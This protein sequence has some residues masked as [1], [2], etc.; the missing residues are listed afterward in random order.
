MNF[1][2]IGQVGKEIQEYENTQIYI[3]GVEPNTGRYLGK[4]IKGYYFSQK[5][6]LSLIDLYYNS[7]YETGEF[8]AEGQRKLFLNI[9]AFRADV[10]S[11]QIDLDTKDFTF[12]PDGK[13]Y[14]WSAFYIQKKFRQWARESYFGDFIN[15]LV[16]NFPKYG[17]LVVKKV[18]DRLVRVPLRDIIIQQDAK[19]IASA[20]Y[21]I[22]EHRGMTIEDM[23]QY[24]DWDVSNVELQYGETTTVYE[25]Y[26]LVPYGFY[27]KA[28]DKPC[29]KDQEDDM[30][31]CVIVAT[32]KANEKKGGFDGNIL[33]IEKIDERP[34]LEVHWKKQ[35][36]RWL[37]VGEVENQFENQVARNMISNMRTRSLKWASKKV[38]QSAGDAIAKNLIRD[39]KDGDVLEVGPNGAIT[40]VDAAS[41]AT[42]EF[43]AAENLWEENSNQKSFTFEVATG[44]A[45]PSGTPFR[46]GVVLSNAVNSHFGLKKEKLG[47]FLKKLVVEFVYDIFIEESREEHIASFMSG[48]EGFEIM[49]QDFIETEMRKRTLDWALKPQTEIPDFQLMRQLITEAYAKQDHLFRE[50]PKDFYESAEVNI[51]LVITGE[52][53]DVAAK[54]TTL[55]TLYQSLVQAG[56][57]RAEKVLS[58]IMTLQG[59]NLELLLGDKPEPAQQQQQLPNAQPVPS[60]IN[61]LAQPQQAPETL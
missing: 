16:E 19:D 35:D 51:D 15:E 39:V 21:F 42:G 44:E 46:L 58:R 8:D 48:E 40:Q 31:D 45:L 53:I 57:P 37:G 22:Q 29:P 28:L 50:V 18:G 32:N 7:K 41:R 11:K 52:E 60:P 59:E 2:I 20:R 34:Y 43:Q 54:I 24:P 49:R 9:C 56:D 1:D 38:F 36:G 17:T 23:K 10:A 5:K 47:L 61:Q 27:C 4:A 55:T 25:R 26:G 12:I 6:T 33:F 14:V 13:D 3:A 30:I